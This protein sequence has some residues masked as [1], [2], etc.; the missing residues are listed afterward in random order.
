MIKNILITG[1]TGLIGLELQKLLQEK[2]YETAVLSRSRKSGDNRSFY[3]DYEKGVLDK[4]ALLFADAIVHLAGENISARRWSPVQKQKIL[5]SRIK[6]TQLL[7]ENIKVLEKKPEVFVSASAVGYY[8]GT[9]SGQIFHEDDIPGRDFL[10]DVTVQWEQSS[11][12]VEVMEIRRVVIRTG[13]V[14][15][16]KGGA[17]PQMMAPVKWGLGTPLGSGKQIISW[18]SL[19]DLVRLYVFTLENPEIS[20]I[21]NAVAPNPSDNRTFMKSLARHLHRPFFLPAV[22]GFI[23]KALLGEMASILLEGQYVSAD[24]ILS[25]GFD[26]KDK[27]LENLLTQL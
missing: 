22:P 1:G 26:F 10:A 3:W 15:S 12:P 14:L 11:Q 13:V 27:S 9:L 8:G 19:D 5:D 24:K 23:L 4:E 17:L 25:E 20:G 21:Y 2:G 18:I 6:T 7:V 16:E